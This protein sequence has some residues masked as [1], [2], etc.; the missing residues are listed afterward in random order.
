MLSDCI[1]GT[2]QD[3][4]KTTELNL[5]GKASGV[6]SAWGRAP[7]RA[8]ILDSNATGMSRSVGN[9]PCGKC[10]CVPR[11][12][13]LRWPA[14]WMANPLGNISGVVYPCGRSPGV[15][16]PREAKA[17]DFEWPGYRGARKR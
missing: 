3:W 8:K 16:K 11:D 2:S 12:C 13:P 14:S 15:S 9:K 6:E 17:T 5:V 4:T 1:S 10:R 7:G